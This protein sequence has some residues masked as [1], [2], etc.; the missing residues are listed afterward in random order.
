MLSVEPTTRRRRNLDVL[1]LVAFGAVV[2]VVALAS[3]LAAGGSRE[4]YATLR[5]PSWAPPDWL[6]SPVW[7]VL[8]VTIAFAGWLVWRQAGLTAAHLPYA[9]QLLLN[10]AWTPLFFGVGAYGW[11]AIEIVVLWLAIGATVVA[12]LRVHRVAAVLL[13]PYWAWVTYATAL[14]LAIWWLNR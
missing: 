9:G 11:A 8:Y 3:G 1:G 12:F 13:L 4:E 6:F 2:A 7:T 10:A 14:N 5:Q